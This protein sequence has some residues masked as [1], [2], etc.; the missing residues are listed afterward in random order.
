MIWKIIFASVAGLLAIIG[1]IPYLRDMF[2][3]KIK[4][5]PYTWF[6]WSI[7]SGVTFVGQ[8][9]K[10]AGWATIAFGLSEFFTILIFFFSLR[11]G[12]KN[13]PKKDTWFLIAALLGIIPWLITKDPTISV[14]IMVAIDLIAFVPTLQKAWRDPS[15]EKA[16]LY[17]SNAARHSLALLALSSY[18]IATMLHSIAMIVTNITMS[19]FILRKK[20]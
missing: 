15:T 2:K 13:I 4:P 18:N 8:V 9:I 5:H 3:R 17:E 12:F 14:I 16:I 10:G 19:A 1:N 20:K 11:Y 6:I 7:V